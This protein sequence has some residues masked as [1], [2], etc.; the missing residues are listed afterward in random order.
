MSMDLLVRLFNPGIEAQGYSPIDDYWYQPVGMQSGAGIMVTPE[1]AMRISAFF[2][3]LRVIGETVL[4]APLK[5]YRRLPNGD[6]EEAPE[7]PLWPILHGDDPNDDQTSAEW[8]ETHTIHT[9]MRGTSWSEIRPG[10]RGPISELAYIHPDRVKVERLSSGMLRYKVMDENSGIEQ[11]WAA[12]RLFRFPGL[13]SNGVTGVSVLEHA[14][15]SLG[16]SLA[17]QQYAGRSFNNGVRTSGVLESPGALK[18]QETVERLRRQWQDTYGGSANA[19]K[20]VILEQGMVYKQVS[21]SNEDAQMLASEQWQ[22]AD[23]ARWFRMPLIMIQEHE[24]STSWGTG[25][26]HQQIGFVVF[27]M[28]PWFIRLEKRVNKQLIAPLGGDYYAE[29]M[30]ESLLRGDIKTMYE[31]FQIAAGGNAPWMT[32]NEIRRKLNMN[33]GG[34]E[35]DEYLQPANMGV[36]GQDTSPPAPSP[37]PRRGGL[38]SDAAAADPR[39][40]TYARVLAGQIVRKESKAIEA[41]ARKHADDGAGWERELGEFYGELVEDLSGR[42]QVEPSVARGYAERWRGRLMEGG[43]G[44]AEGWESAKSEEL[45]GLMLGASFDE[46]RM[47]GEVKSS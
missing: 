9:A 28:L 39:L 42:C 23:I 27:T 40:R 22:V 15:E 10:S 5:V 18:D 38:P 17:L 25:V 24:K 7:H 6:R 12:D 33:R 35:L 29:F 21:M 11:V 20:T 32:R 13:S 2:A 36:A 47:S 44:A 4:T 46:L 37:S 8:R 1:T 34:E 30:V 31:A 26:E 14:R 45:L 19:G 16:I 3:C 41:L 43:A